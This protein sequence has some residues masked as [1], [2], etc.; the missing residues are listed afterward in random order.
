MTG[1]RLD[2]DEEVRQHRARNAAE[3]IE[4]RT[5]TAGVLATMRSAGLSG[6]EAFAAA[7]DRAARDCADLVLAEGDWVPVT[8]AAHAYRWLTDRELRAYRIGL[9]R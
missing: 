5:Y 9:A 2:L 6:R 8:R 4:R 7:A 1:R 3:R